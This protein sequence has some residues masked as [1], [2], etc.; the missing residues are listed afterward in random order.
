MQKKKHII[1]EWKKWSVESKK[2]E[3]TEVELEKQVRKLLKRSRSIEAE[4][5]LKITK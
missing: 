4:P 2:L 3:W 1:K 5:I